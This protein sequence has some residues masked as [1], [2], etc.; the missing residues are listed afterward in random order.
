MFII[1]FSL[2]FFT[3]KTKSFDIKLGKFY[4]CI[5]GLL[6]LLILSEAITKKQ[7]IDM[8]QRL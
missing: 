1:V 6:S 4:L 5:G 8:L 3:K 7:A 2:A